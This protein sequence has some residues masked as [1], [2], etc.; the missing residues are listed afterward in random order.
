MGFVHSITFVYILI[1]SPSTSL[2]V[3]IPYTALVQPFIL[4][5]LL[6]IKTQRFGLVAFTK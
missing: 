1:I 3:A 5:L 6:P 4:P 2:N